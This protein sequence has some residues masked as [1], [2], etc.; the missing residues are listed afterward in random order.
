MQEK[1][2]KEDYIYSYIAPGHYFSV[3]EVQGYR[4][5]RRVP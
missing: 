2:R 3:D 1:I 5:I 4:K